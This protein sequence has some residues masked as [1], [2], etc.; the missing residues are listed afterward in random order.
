MIIERKH[1]EHKHKYCLRKMRFD[2]A[3]YQGVFYCFSNS[4]TTT[5]G[6]TTAIADIAAKTAQLEMRATADAKAKLQRERV[7]RF[8]AASSPTP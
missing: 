5:P 7:L 1:C 3:E 2:N 6:V 8:M 4:T